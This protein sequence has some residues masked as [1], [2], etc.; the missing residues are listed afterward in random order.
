MY[1]PISVIGVGLRVGTLSKSFQVNGRRSWRA[2]MGVLAAGQPEPMVKQPISYD[3]AFG[4]I[5]IDPKRPERIETYL[6][7]PVGCGFRKHK[8]DLWGLPMPLTE[9]VSDPIRDPKKRYRP[10]AFGPLGRNWK[11]RMEHAGTYDQRWM[12]DVSPMLPAD[13]N[14]LYFQAAPPDQRIPYPKGGE[15]IR[16][17]NLVPP[18]LSPN[19]RA[20][21][22]V[23]TTRIAMVFVPRTGEPIWADADLDTLVLEPDENRFTCSWR[24]SYATIRDASEIEEVVVCQRGTRAETRTRAHLRGKLYYAGLGQLARRR[25]GGDE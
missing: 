11:P 16:L 3:V 13:F 17:V 7:N 12:D 14:P 25:K 2:I 24:A 5:E 15:P 6:E 9:E 21:S 10:M 8:I 1:R 22:S 18:A 4:G 19:A 23:P 20:E